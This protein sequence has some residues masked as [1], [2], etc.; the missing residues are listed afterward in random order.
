MHVYPGT[1]FHS[2]MRIPAIDLRIDTA[3]VRAYVH[4]CQG[5]MRPDM[6]TSVAQDCALGG[7]CFSLDGHCRSILPLVSISARHEDI[8][9]IVKSHSGGSTLG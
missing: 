9:T 1:I 8:F 2:D 6:L 5:S 3:I 7:C 4:V